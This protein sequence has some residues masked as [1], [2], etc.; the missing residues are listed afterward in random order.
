MWAWK[1]ALASCALIWGGSFVII[2]GSLD[3]MPA[4]SLMALRFLLAALLLGAVCWRQLR[5]NFDWS[6]LLAGSILGV[7]A[8]AAYAVQN[9]G[10]T[11]TTPGRSAF[12]TAVYCVL[13]PFVNWVVARRKPGA[14][15]VLAAVLC[16]AG[17]GLIS[18]GEDL[19]PSL[20]AGEQLTLLSALLFALQIVFVAKFAGAH[21]MMTLTVIQMAVSS[22]ACWVF[23]LLLGEPATD[24]STLDASFWWSLAYM[25]VLASCVCNAVQNVAQTVVPPAPAALLLSLESVFAV[26][27]SVIFYGEQLTPRLVAGFA[28]I[29]VAVLASE[30]GP[31][32]VRRVLASRS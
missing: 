19:V 15:S 12:L 27:A 20:G 25:V 4:C 17:V 5:D 7:L 26:V 13:V 2:K 8:G 22:A 18:L 6:H 30:L 21:D 24:L 11:Y 14:T 29:F 28:L 9:V 32:L 16:M 1:L 31:T 10:L 3:A 23:S